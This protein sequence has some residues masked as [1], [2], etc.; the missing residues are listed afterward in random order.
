[1]RR[2]FLLLMA[3][4]W[5][6]TVIC[7]ASPS[8]VMLEFSDDT[9]YDKLQTAKNLSARVM[10]RLINSD[11]FNLGA[12]EPIKADIAARLYDDKVRGYEAMEAA[13]ESDDFDEVF[14]EMIN[15]R[16]AQSIATAQVGQIISP[17]LT[18]KIGKRN[19]ADYLIQGTIINL[20]VGNWLNEDYSAMSHAINMSS[21]FTGMPGSTS[22]LGLSNP[23]GSTVSY[24]VKKTGIGV[25]CDVRVIKA[26]TGEVVWSKRV[27][28]VAT[29]KMIDMGVVRLGRAKLNDAL[30]TKAL[31]N[32]AENI[33]STLIADLEA[34]KLFLR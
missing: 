24:D 12:D 14:E 11:K 17:E 27:T 2:I 21:T 15:G 6:M 1:M 22:A 16:N 4:L 28:G 10:S 18:S 29:Q 7:S 13:F 33:V 9:R 26:S 19:H 34:G 23:L 8:C 3:L 30:R 32:A 5:T 25:Q 20:G 31:D